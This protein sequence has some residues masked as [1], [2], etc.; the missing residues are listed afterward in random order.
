MQSTI[1]PVSFSGTGGTGFPEIRGTEPLN[2]PQDTTEAGTGFLSSA[3]SSDNDFHVFDSASDDFFTR[4]FRYLLF[5]FHQ[6]DWCSLREL[7]EGLM[8]KSAA[9]ADT[10]ID[11]VTLCQPHLYHREM[12]LDLL[13]CLERFD[14]KLFDVRCNFV[15]LDDA[16]RLRKHVTKSIKSQPAITWKE[17]VYKTLVMHGCH[18]DEIG[19]E[20]IELVNDPYLI[21]PLSLQRRR[22]AVGG[23]FISVKETMREILEEDNRFDVRFQLQNE[24]YK[25]F[26]DSETLRRNGDR[27]IVLEK[28]QKTVPRS[29][30]APEYSVFLREKPLYYIRFY[31]ISATADEDNHFGK[32][33]E[34]GMSG[35]GVSLHKLR[36][37]PV[38]NNIGKS[39]ENQ[40]WSQRKF[41]GNFAYR[42]L[43]EYTGTLEVGVHAS[44][45]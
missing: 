14:G 8:D 45:E 39:R 7:S 37:V 13:G 42:I 3:A 2:I 4:A 24:R 1:S 38:S 40:I 5:N 44:V 33:D 9:S 27:E 10:G 35:C 26:A 18:S 21:M 6:L 19:I 43:A 22:E 17:R 41:I 32:I 28:P 34:P 20:L 25:Q 29:K 31:G 23:E 30:F 36:L 12:N 15:G 16:V 11:R